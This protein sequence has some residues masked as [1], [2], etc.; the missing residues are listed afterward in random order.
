MQLKVTNQSTVLGK[1]ITLA[2][3]KET[4]SIMD[5]PFHTVLLGRATHATQPLT[6]EDNREDTSQ[7]QVVDE[8]PEHDNGSDIQAE[9]ISSL[10]GD[11][12]VR[13]A[14]DDSASVPVVHD[15][16]SI[17]LIEVEYT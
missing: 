6:S 8:A 9:H 11:P 12:Y 17:P 5:M 3:F 10:K 7:P 13:E 15:P 1:G 14:E 2:S 16:S 4:T